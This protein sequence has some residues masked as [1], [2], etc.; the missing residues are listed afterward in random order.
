L[1]VHSITIKTNLLQWDPPIQIHP[2]SPA[3]TAPFE[4]FVTAPNIEQIMSARL[5]VQSEDYSM[6]LT[7]TTES[8]EASSVLTEK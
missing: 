1:Q 6:I 4:I 2:M 7:T 3:T 8:T 5:N